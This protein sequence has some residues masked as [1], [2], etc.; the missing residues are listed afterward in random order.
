MDPIQEMCK[1]AI[2]ALR[3]EIVK[4]DEYRKGLVKKYEEW[5]K[6]LTPPA[7]VKAEDVDTIPHE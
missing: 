4:T 5:T 1:T 6:A 7:E 2:E 3:N